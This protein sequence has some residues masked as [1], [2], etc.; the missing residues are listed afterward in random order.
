MEMPAAEVA[1]AIDW[2][3]LAPPPERPVRLIKVAIGWFA[4][5][6]LAVAMNGFVIGVAVGVS[7]HAFEVPVGGTTASSMI[8]FQLVLLLSAIHRAKTIGWQGSRADGFG[9]APVRRLWLLVMLAAILLSLDGLGWY[10]RMHSPRA[11]WKV[12]NAAIESAFAHG[13][14]LTRAALV[15]GI[16]VL[17]PISEELFFRGWL[18]T[19]LRRFWFP[20]PVMLATG[21]PWLLIHML[22]GVALP[23]HLWPHAIMFSLA[24][25]FCG[26][27]RASIGLHIVSNLPVAALFVWS[28]AG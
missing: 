5:G 10:A 2:S 17:A 6:G 8:A 11:D 1:L 13:S 4:L 23:L 22:D 26:D 7:H 12:T 16:V 24:R 15:F 3:S 19:G 25:H 14:T 21:T 9:L 18:W 27:V 20:F 28:Y